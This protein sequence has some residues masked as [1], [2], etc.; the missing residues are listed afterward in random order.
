[1]ETVSS[2]GGTAGGADGMGFV[3]CQGVQLCSR[4]PREAFVTGKLPLTDA[5]VTDSP[6]L[7]NLNT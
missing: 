4:K 3:Q 2:L 1:M 5:E 7:L 6:S